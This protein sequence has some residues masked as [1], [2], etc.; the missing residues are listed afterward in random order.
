MTR[1]GNR[2]M[3]GLTMMTRRRPMFAAAWLLAAAP[4][5]QAGDASLSADGASARAPSVDEGW[6]AGAAANGTPAASPAVRNAGGA[7]REAAVDRLPSDGVPSPAGS[8]M[9]AGYH[10]TAG[11]LGY[12]A[13]VHVYNYPGLHAGAGGTGLLDGADG[14]TEMSAGLNWKSLYARYDVV[15]TRDYLGIPGARGTGYFDVGAHHPIGNATFLNLHAGDARVAGVGNALF[16]WKDLRAGFS[17]KLEDGWMMV[18]NVRR[19]Y[20]NSALADRRGMML[21]SEGHN[22]ALA[23]GHRGLV[24]TFNRG[25]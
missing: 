3:S 13:L 21:R 8:D 9:F 15:L 23:R 1:Y 17:R 12:S 7:L 11:G 24:L 16:D 25:F 18:L 14:H 10:G 20:G 5:A 6:F 4:L 19:V 2:N 22:P